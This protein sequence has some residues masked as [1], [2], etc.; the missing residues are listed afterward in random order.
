MIQLRAIDILSLLIASLTKT[1]IF[2]FFIIALDKMFIDG[3]KNKRI[4]DFLSEGNRYPKM[5]RQ[6]FIFLFVLDFLIS[7]YYY[8]TGGVILSE[9]ALDIILGPFVLTIPLL[10]FMIY[11]VR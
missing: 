1:G 10:V 7:F 11:Y 2:T 4:R 6:I 3:I 8:I 5:H 9:C